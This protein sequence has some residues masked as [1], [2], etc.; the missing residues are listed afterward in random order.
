MRAGEGKRGGLGGEGKLRR[1]G[2]SA[3][4]EFNLFSSKVLIKRILKNHEGRRK[5]GGG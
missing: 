3:T 2:T 1:D 4:K 5:G